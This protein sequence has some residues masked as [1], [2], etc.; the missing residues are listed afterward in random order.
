MRINN[1]P[2]ILWL[3]ARF[4][5]V[6][7][8]AIPSRYTI[9]DYGENYAATIRIKDASSDDAMLIEGRPERLLELAREILRVAELVAEQTMRDPALRR[10][11][12]IIES[13]QGG[14][15]ER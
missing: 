8:S 14:T 7:G 12:G 13:S 5:E 15:V 2:D 9:E 6:D 11:Y 1:G 10:L 4:T 3:S